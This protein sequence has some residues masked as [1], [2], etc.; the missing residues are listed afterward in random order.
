MSGRLQRARLRRAFLLATSAAAV[1]LLGLFG[2]EHLD[3]ARRE[4]EEMNAEIR[5]LEHRLAR[6]QGKHA[7]GEGVEPAAARLP[8]VEAPAGTVLARAELQSRLRAIALESGATLHSVEARTEE[9][10]PGVER[11]TF[12]LALA[13]DHSALRAFLLH[14]EEGDPPFAIER[15]EVAAA[16]ENEPLEVRLRPTIFLLAPESNP[17]Q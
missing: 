12:E 5:L 13:A 9:S 1:L 17:T 15:I 11:L 2:L 14:L 4:A 6:L 7:V 10:G 8:L 16:G 3:R